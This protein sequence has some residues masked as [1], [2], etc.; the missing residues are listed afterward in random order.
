MWSKIHHLDHRGN[1][2]FLNYRELIKDVEKKMLQPYHKCWY[3]SYDISKGAVNLG[4]SCVDGF[5]H[6]YYHK[7]PWDFACVSI[8]APINASNEE[9]GDV[10]QDISYMLRNVEGGHCHVNDIILMLQSMFF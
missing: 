1:I 9:E 4:C 5:I 2:S 10:M 3:G 8:S 7:R 6:H